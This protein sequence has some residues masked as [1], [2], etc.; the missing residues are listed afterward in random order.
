MSASLV[1]SEMCIRDRAGRHR[2]PPGLGSSSSRRQACGTP[3]SSS[4]QNSK[5]LST[6]LRAGSSIRNETTAASVRNE[7]TTASAQCIRNEATTAE[8]RAL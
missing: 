3:A 1:G 8:E 5:R 4:F 6:P 2:R 7:T